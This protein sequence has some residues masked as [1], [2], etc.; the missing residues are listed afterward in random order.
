MISG[1]TPFLQVLNTHFELIRWFSDPH[2]GEGSF[3]GVSKSAH[4]PPD[5]EKGVISGVGG[6]ILRVILGVPDP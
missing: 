5:P 1:F 6:H 2:S 3:S 4:F